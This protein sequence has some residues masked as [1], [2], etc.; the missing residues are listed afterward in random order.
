MKQTTKWQMNTSS[1]I[2]VRDEW[3]LHTAFVHQVH[4]AHRTRVDGVKKQQ[5]HHPN[6]YYGQDHISH[7]DRR[8]RINLEPALVQPNYGVASQ[9]KSACQDLL[10]L[11]G[12]LWLQVHRSGWLHICHRTKLEEARCT[13]RFARWDLESVG[14]SV[15]CYLRVRQIYKLR[16]LCKGQEQDTWS[17]R[18]ER[19]FC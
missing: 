15:R 7:V 8:C 10:H 12:G 16:L 13:M 18:V 9:C 17:T 11:K 2:K 19:Y 1:F 4:Q 6:L 14:G 3:M 5:R